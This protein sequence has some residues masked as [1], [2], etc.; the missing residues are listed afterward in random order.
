MNSKRIVEKLNH[1]IKNVWELLSDTD[2]PE[3]WN[4]FLDTRVLEGEI[5]EKNMYYP[6]KFALIVE[7]LIEFKVTEVSHSEMKISFVMYAG[8]LCI[9]MEFRLCEVDNITHIEFEVSSSS[10]IP[11]F[12]ELIE[13]LSLVSDVLVNNI[14]VIC[15]ALY[16]SVNTVQTNE[17]PVG[18]FSARHPNFNITEIKRVS[19]SDGFDNILQEKS[20]VIL[21]DYSQSLPEYKSL[22]DF[23]WWKSTF[24]RQ[25]ILFMDFPTVAYGEGEKLCMTTIDMLTKMLSANQNQRKFAVYEHQIHRIIGLSR[26]LSPPNII[27]TNCCIVR[28][29]IWLGSGKLRSPMHQDNAITDTTGTAPDKTHNLNFQIKGRKKVILAHPNQ[30]QYLYAQPL[31][32]DTE[33]PP[34]IPF[35]IF[36]SI[37]LERYP[38][39]QNAHFYETE[40]E[41]GELLYI[42]RGWWHAF[43]AMENSINYNTFFSSPSV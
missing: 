23:D 29:N 15:G 26:Y 25:T 30:T 24:G 12:Y 11:E 31:P 33:L 14:T 20:P 43:Y 4:V 5:R 6:S 28:E 10:Q 41:E 17:Q 13:I 36:N 22:K 19:L 7:G 38:K 18:S 27:P 1:N 8:G 39:V 16:S 35:D 37:D 3:N 34:T 32:L 40:L 9:D 2:N 42:P 21:Y